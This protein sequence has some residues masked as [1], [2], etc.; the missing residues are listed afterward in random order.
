MSLRGD[1]LR[2]TIIIATILVA[3]FL[4][5]ANTV[6]TIEGVDKSSKMAAFL[7]RTTGHGVLLFGL[8]AIALAVQPKDQ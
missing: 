8:I 6:I 1:A 2:W 5:I 4:I 3:L 7:E